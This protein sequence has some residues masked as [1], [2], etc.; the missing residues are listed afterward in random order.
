MYRS[1]KFRLTNIFVPV[2]LAVVCA[3]GP[4]LLR[5]QDREADKADKEKEVRITE[6]I[7]VTGKTPKEQPVSTVTTISTVQIE[8]QKPRD[9]ADVLRFAPGASVS[10]G[11]KEEFN[12]KLRG[13]DNKRIALLVDGIP[14][15]D[16]YYSSFDL[17]TVSSGGI[18]SIQVTK[19]PS[20]VLYG[21]NTLGGIVNV[22]TRRPGPDPRLSLN[23]SYG[24]KNTWNAGLDTS[25]QWGKFGMVA[26]AFY[27]NSDGFY[28]N[29]GTERT[30]RANSD[31]KRL[32]LNA[33]LYYN[34]TSDS[35]IMVNGGYYHS[36]YG[37][38]PD[39]SSSKPRYWRFPDWDRY[40]LN[41]GGYTALSEKS[42]LRFRAFYVNYKNTLDWFKDKAMSIRTSQ[43]D[44]N[45]SDYG[46]FGIGEFG[47]SDWNQLKVS[48]YYQG[49][50]VE[51]RD[52]VSL[53]WVNYDQGTF[54]AGVEENISLSEQWKVIGGLSF[55][56]LDKMTGKNTSRVNPQVGIKF[57]PNDYLDVHVSFSNKSRF[58]SMRSMYSTS[59]GN[60]NLLS[61]RAT[62]WEV[63]ATYNRGVL[64]SAAVFSNDIKGMIDTYRLPDGT[65]LY[66]N[67]GKARIRG[68]EIQAQKSL[69]GL[70]MTVN[71]TYLDHKNV[72]DNRP[73]DV[74]PNHNL[75][76]N[77][78]FSPLDKLHLGVFGLL[79]SDSDWF[80]TSTSK[81][82]VIPSYFNL[83]AILSFDMGAFDPFVKVSNI[84]NKDF[85]TEPGFPWRGR[86][87][88]FGLKADI[89]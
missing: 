76:F 46:I 61:E 55:D 62:T 2:L 85:Y 9:L 70:D 84:F 37:M 13:F 40:T 32:N 77:L 14:V 44:F 74:L 79:A 28:Y 26:D 4:A 7:L 48:V 75:N 36:E 35:E 5:A 15:I 34:P 64:L 65:R 31:Y 68:F 57:T 63:G 38:P 78:D 82:Q 22:I 86:F 45:N 25:Y 42:T 17:K 83:E 69:N 24:D 71:Y 30:L 23:A 88:E 33:K 53:P 72:S 47:L 18:A 10:F 6:E 66:F 49:D 16:P 20:S 19:G 81:I 80:N 60:P 27:Q 1:I 51:T 89:F 87:I 43:S 54:S 12:L 52:D 3:A 11:N 56:Y 59:S 67:I 39:L 41:A 73:L 8:L 58:P 21:P 50:K 29:N